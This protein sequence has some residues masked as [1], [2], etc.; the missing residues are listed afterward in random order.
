MRANGYAAI[1]VQATFMI[2]PTTVISTAF[3]KLGIISL[4]LNTVS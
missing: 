1:I 2:V 4:F 3:Q